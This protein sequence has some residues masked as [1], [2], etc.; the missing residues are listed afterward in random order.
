ME[1]YKAIV[2][3]NSK[4]LPLLPV[5]CGFCKIIQSPLLTD[6]IVKSAILGLRQFLA[7]KCHFKIMKNAF[8]FYLDV[9]FILKIFKFLS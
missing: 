2:N 8:Y 5:K 7:T 3:E 9:F 6:A 4:P 1:I